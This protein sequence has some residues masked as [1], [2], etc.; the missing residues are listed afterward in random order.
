[1]AYQST[2]GVSVPDDKVIIVNGTPVN[3]ETGAQVFPVNQKP[4]Q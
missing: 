3:K 2:G 4:Q 1:M